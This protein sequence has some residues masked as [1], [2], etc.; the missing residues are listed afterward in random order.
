VVL[1]VLPQRAQRSFLLADLLLGFPIEFA[2]HVFVAMGHRI[3]RGAAQFGNTQKV[4]LHLD[5][6]V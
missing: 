3:R 5:D 4:P 6:A 2:S 1:P